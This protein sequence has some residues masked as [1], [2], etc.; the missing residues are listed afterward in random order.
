[1]V[2][3]FFGIITISAMVNMIVIKDYVMK[4]FRFHSIDSNTRMTSN[5][6]ASIRFAVPYSN[7]MADS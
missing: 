5:F 3:I 1:M 4:F 6:T 2:V 7:V